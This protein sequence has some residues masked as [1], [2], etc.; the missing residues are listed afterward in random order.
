MSGSP[1][2]GSAGVRRSRRSRIEAIDTLIG[3][4]VPDTLASRA[5]YE[6]RVFLPMYEAIAPFDPDGV[7][8]MEVIKRILDTVKE[9]A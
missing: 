9:R 7:D 2:S 5:E 3:D 6:H 8:T 1:A 4:I